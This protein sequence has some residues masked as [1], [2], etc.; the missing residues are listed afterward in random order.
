M[1]LVC[2]HPQV[3]I[4]ASLLLK[5][6]ISWYKQQLPVGRCNWT[7]LFSYNRKEEVA[8][9]FWVTCLAYPV[10]STGWS[11]HQW[12][13]DVVVLHSGQKFRAL[14]NIRLQQYSSL[15]EGCFILL[16]CR[17]RAWKL[18]SSVSSDSLNGGQ[19]QRK[20]KENSNLRFNREAVT[21]SCMQDTPVTHGLLGLKLFLFMVLL[22][23]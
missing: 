19:M 4:F 10:D 5:G 23:V 16:L 14:L 11:W 8:Q 21:M 6:R 2:R 22:I 17:V 9:R 7:R 15:G 13:I 12:E 20:L 3:P 1:Q 18:V